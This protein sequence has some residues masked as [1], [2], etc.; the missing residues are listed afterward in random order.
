MKKEDKIKEKERGVEGCSPSAFALYTQKEET[1]N[2][3][4]SDLDEKNNF[5][6]LLV[7]LTCILVRFKRVRVFGSLFVEISKYSL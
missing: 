7:P 3:Y 6:W 2:N 1:S 5:I 4:S